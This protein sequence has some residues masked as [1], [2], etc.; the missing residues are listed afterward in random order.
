MR[1]IQI[2]EQTDEAKEQIMQERK[3]QNSLKIAALKNVKAVDDP[4]ELIEDMA[5]YLSEIGADNSYIDKEVMRARGISNDPWVHITR[6]V[7]GR[8]TM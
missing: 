2:Y 4:N 1:K 6:G 3:R 8:E 7:I 5:Q